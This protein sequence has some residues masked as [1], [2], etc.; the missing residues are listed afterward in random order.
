MAVISTEKAARSV[1][2][3]WQSHC[4]AHTMFLSSCSTTVTAQCM[5]TVNLI[6]L[7]EN[8]C[9]LHNYCHHHP[10]HATSSK[11]LQSKTRLTHASAALAAVRFA[12]SLRAPLPAEMLCARD[13]AL[14]AAALLGAPAAAAAAL[15]LLLP[16]VAAV[17]RRLA[18][19]ASL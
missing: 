6:L 17:T 16:A 11:C 18:I 19:R 8:K 4:E 9:S 10:S 15:L 2:L 5:H 7:G 14:A 13:R 1:L 12:V 3:S